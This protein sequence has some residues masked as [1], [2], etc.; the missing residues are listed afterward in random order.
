MAFANL[1]RLTDEYDDPKEDLRLALHQATR[2]T[3][4]LLEQALDRSPIRELARFLWKLKLKVVETDTFV[5]ITLDNLPDV[6]GESIA[7]TLDT[8]D[9][10]HFKLRASPPNAPDMPASAVRDGVRSL[11][12]HLALP[13]GIDRKF[14]MA[15]FEDGRITVT[16]PKRGHESKEE[17]ISVKTRAA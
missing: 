11:E 6:D 15:R 10:L 14:A 1:L 2:A 5:K 8:H 7:I 17:S 4:R 9:V 16:L 13:P 3:R 12:R